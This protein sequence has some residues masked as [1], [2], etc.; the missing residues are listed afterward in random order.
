MN[1]KSNKLLVLT[2]LSCTLL[3]SCGQ[4]ELAEKHY[5][6]TVPGYE[7][8]V[9]EAE[10]KEETQKI[11]LTSAPQPSTAI[12]VVYG[13]IPPGYIQPTFVQQGPAGGGNAYGALNSTI[14]PGAIMQNNAQIYQQPSSFGSNYY[15][16]MGR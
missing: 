14:Q 3:C 16:Q 7:E 9:E 5:K 12:P 15:P 10:R 1:A 13:T 2:A 4:Q 11:A 8:K 6:S